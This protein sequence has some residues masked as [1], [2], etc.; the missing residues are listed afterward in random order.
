MAEERRLQM[1]AEKAEMLAH[2]AELAEQRTEEAWQLRLR[3]EAQRREREAKIDAECKRKAQQT[4]VFLQKRTAQVAA[5][6]RE[7]DV[8]RIPG[9]LSRTSTTSTIAS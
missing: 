9:S 5:R 6:L 3:V 7:H 1:M 8:W 4:D 2:R